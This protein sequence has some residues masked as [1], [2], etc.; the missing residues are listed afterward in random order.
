MVAIWCRIFIAL[1]VCPGVLSPVGVTA[2]RVVAAALLLFFIQRY[3]PRPLCASTNWASQT[4]GC[5]LKLA[6]GEDTA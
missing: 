4:I 6:F 2:F 1:K 3:N 5:F